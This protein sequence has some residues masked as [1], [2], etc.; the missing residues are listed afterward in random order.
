MKGARV[1]F[2][3]FGGL[4]RPRFAGRLI[5]CVDDDAVLAALED[6]L[7]LKL[8]GLL[9]AIGAVKK[10]AARVDVDGACRLTDADVVRLR[11]RL[12]LVGDLGI[13][14]AVLYSVGVHFVLRLDGD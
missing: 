8:D 7:A 6:L 12:R 13:Y 2:V 1:E 14:P 3:G 5:D 4:D 10:T 11:Q 9:G